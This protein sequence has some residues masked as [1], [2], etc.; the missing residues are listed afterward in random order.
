LQSN[1]VNTSCGILHSPPGAPSQP[2]PPAV[3]SVAGSMT[4]TPSVTPQQRTPQPQLH[5]L[6]VEARRSQFSNS[7]GSEDVAAIVQAVV[8]FVRLSIDRV[9]VGE[10]LSVPQTEDLHNEVVALTFVDLSDK[11]TGRRLRVRD[12]QLEVALYQLCEEEQPATERINHDGEEVSAAAT[13]VLPAASLEGVWESLMFG[14]DVKPRLLGYAHST[15]RF[16]DAG[17]DPAVVNCNRLILLHGEPGTG[18]TSLCRALAHKLSIHMADRY[19]Y[20]CLVEVNSHSLFSKWFSESGKLVQ[21][22][23]DKLHEHLADERCLVF[24]LVDEVE[25]LSAARQ[26]CLSGSDPSDSIRVVN[27]LLTQLDA[28]KRWPNVLV[29][30]TSNITGAID[31]AFLDRCDLCLHIGLPDEPAVY[32]ILASCLRELL[33]AGVVSSAS[34]SGA[35]EPP[36]IYAYSELNLL[37]GAASERLAQS[38]TFRCSFRLLALS[39]A[40]RGLSGRRLRKLPLLA[41]SVSLADCR[42]FRNDGAAG[43]L[44]DSFLVAMETAAVAAAP[45]GVS[46]NG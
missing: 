20:G 15:L 43:L 6:V 29:L 12:C 46:T 32:E 37:G 23:F 21:K 2:V 11:L 38:D 27:A 1:F 40:C 5:R 41:H 34:A 36:A 42:R 4:S 39:R 35:A 16:A 26:A 24:V 30:T 9:T 25:S 13:L 28:V 14:A 18:K 10:R 3:E 19:D 45:V 7:A 33:R 31:E 22:M 17:V 8:Q 44:L